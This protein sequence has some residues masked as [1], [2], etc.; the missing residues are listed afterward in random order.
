MPA[1]SISIFAH[2]TAEEGLLL[3]PKTQVN[4]FSFDGLTFVVWFELRQT[5]PP[6]RFRTTYYFFLDYSN[7]SLDLVRPRMP[8]DVF[9]CKFIFTTSISLFIVIGRSRGLAGMIYE[10]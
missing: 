3:D 7:L 5:D 2:L 6:T 10:F 1:A 9:V 4:L 8:L